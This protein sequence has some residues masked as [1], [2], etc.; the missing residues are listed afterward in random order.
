MGVTMTV[1]CEG[2]IAALPNQ[3]CRRRRHRGNGAWP[4]TLR[5]VQGLD[6]ADSASTTTTDLRGN[7]LKPDPAWGRSLP[8]DR[9]MG[10]GTHSGEQ[11]RSAT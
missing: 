11:R 2:S 10:S 6:P 4:N 3:A 7:A 1:P 5:A 9:L 8:S